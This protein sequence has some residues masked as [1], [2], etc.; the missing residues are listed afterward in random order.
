MFPSNLR[1]TVI[2]CG[3]AAARL[4]A[5]PQSEGCLFSWLCGG[6]CPA[7]APVTTYSIPYSACATPCSASYSACSPCAAP[8]SACSPCAV[9]YS[10]GRATL[11]PVVA[12]PR[13]VYS[14]VAQ[15]CYSPVSQS[16]Y[17]APQTTYRW[18]YSRISWTRFRPVTAVDPCTGCATTSYQPVT[19]RTLLPW[20]HREP[21]TSYRMVCSPTYASS[22]GPVCAPSCGTGCA[23]SSTILGA[24]SYSAPVTTVPGAITST[25][26]VDPGYAPPP[27]FKTEQ[28]TSPSGPSMGGTQRPQLD[29][30]PSPEVNTNPTSLEQPRL[31]MPSYSKT[32]ARPV[33]HAGYH[34]PIDPTPST[35]PAMPMALDVSG[36]RASQD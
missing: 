10:V 14:P 24:P 7:P 31:I 9:P 23:P 28:G 27:T 21:V 22:C 26:G 25:P 32:A 16:C 8:Y 36:W 19:R 15:A 18:T 12:A 2:A 30:R 3:L 1:I 33:R 6:S 17:Y 34:R 35:G 29:L 5:P 20:L 4:V 13:V 11:M